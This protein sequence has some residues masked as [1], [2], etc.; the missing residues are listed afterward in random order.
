MYRSPGGQPRSSRTRTRRPQPAQ[1]RADHVRPCRSRRCAPCSELPAADRRARRSRSGSGTAS[2]CSSP[3]PTSPGPPC[4]YSC[5]RRRAGPRRH[6]GQPPRAHRRFP[7]CCSRPPR[8]SGP[9][10]PPRPSR[11][12][13]SPA[14]QPRTPRGPCSRQAGASASCRT[15]RHTGQGR[16]SPPR[17]EPPPLHPTLHPTRSRAGS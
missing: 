9:I 12:E 15:T 11:H 1:T 13:R 3:L 8:A 7:L 10:A 4:G 16:P 17:G 2:G 6:P 5:W 14:T